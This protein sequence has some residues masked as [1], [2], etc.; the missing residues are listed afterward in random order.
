MNFSERNIFLYGK[1]WTS[2]SVQERFFTECSWKTLLTMCIVYLV[3]LK[4]QRQTE[5]MEF[6]QWTLISYPHKYNK[7][8]VLRSSRISRKSAAMIARCNQKKEWI[9]I[10]FYKRGTTG[11]IQVGLSAKCTSKWV[12]PKLNMSHVRVLT[13]FP[14]SH[15]ILHQSAKAIVVT[16]CCLVSFDRLCSWFLPMWSATPRLLCLFA[17]WLRM[18][19]G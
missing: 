16:I 19:W 18:W 2:T 6:M 7:L 4:R 12:L 11:P 14:R 3:D 8:Y 10:V 1:K 5:F 15:H 17:T 13:D 9:S